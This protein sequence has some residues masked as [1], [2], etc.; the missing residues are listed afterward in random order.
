MEAN[1]TSSSKIE[2]ECV[3][4]NGDILGET[5]SASLLVSHSQRGVFVFFIIF[6][7]NS[8]ATFTIFA[9]FGLIG[10]LVYKCGIEKELDDLKEGADLD[11]DGK[12]SLEEVTLLDTGCRLPGL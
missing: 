1:C 2:A 4:N 12:V 11:G 9:I 8:Q 5:Y 6:F 10:L 7:L 3:V